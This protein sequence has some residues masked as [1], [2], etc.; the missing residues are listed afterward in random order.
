LKVFNEIYDEG[1]NFADAFAEL[2]LHLFASYGL[3]VMNPVKRDLMSLVGPIIKNVLTD[4]DTYY[5]KFKKISKYL[6]NKGYDSQI[7]LD[8][9]Q[10]LLFIENEDKQRC[11]IDRYDKLFEIKNLGNTTRCS[12][13]DLLTIVQQAPEKFT[14]NVALRPILQDLLL[15]TAAYIG[16]PAE[17]SYAAQLLPLY[18]SAQVTQPIFY[19]RIRATIIEKKIHKLFEK[20]ELNFTEIFQDR[21]EIINKY[22]LDQKDKKVT[23]IVQQKHAEIQSVLEKLKEV[24]MD[25]EPTLEGSIKKTENN[26]YELLNKLNVKS[27][28]ALKVKLD[29]QIRQLNK[30]II[31]FFPQDEYQ[32]RILNFLYYQIKYGPQFIPELFATININD[33]NHQLIFIK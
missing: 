6:E 28:E 26:I 16:G 11:R 8:P 30:I 17:I 18:Q 13:K 15:P 33:C 25:V 27:N 20:F 23:R 5:L 1:K 32:E 9:H 19:P 21:K 7:K 2:L 12:E 22:I 31:N 24:L 3:I 29:T 14:P 10:T 4:S